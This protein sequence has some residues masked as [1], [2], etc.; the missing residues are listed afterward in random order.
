MA[1][2]GNNSSGMQ[3]E[4]I[5]NTLVN[6]IS[7]FTE[8]SVEHLGYDKTVLAS[9]QYC[10]DATLG[11]YKIKYQNGYYTAY[12]QDKSTIYANGAAVYVLVPGNDM[13]NK[14]FITGLV[15]NDN[16]LRTYI[17]NLD[18]DQLYGLTSVNLFSTIDEIGLSSYETEAMSTNPETEYSLTLYDY[19]KDNNIIALDQAKIRTEIMKSNTDA[20]NDDKHKYLRFGGTF[21]T[22]FESYRKL[23]PGA[24]YGIRL[25]I[26]FQDSNTKEWTDKCYALNTFNME[27]NP[28]EFTSGSPRYAY[29]EIDPN[30]YQYVR[31]IVAYIKGFP[32]VDPNDRHYPLQPDNLFKDLKI[33]DISLYTAKKLYSYDN[34]KYRI[35]LDYSKTDKY[36][37]STVSQIE[38]LAHFTIDGN[39]VIDESQNVK[40]Y[41]GKEDV[42]VD[43]IGHAK[44]NKFL[45]KGWRCI[46]TWYAKKTDSSNPDDLKNCA[47]TAVQMP[48]GSVK[49]IGWNSVNPILLTSA[50][51]KAKQTLIKCVA[52]YEN[53]PYQTTE[54]F[55][56]NNGKYLLVKSSNPT[57]STTT[58][59]SAGVFADNPVEGEPPLNWT[60]RNPN[61]DT[62]SN[63]T[64]IW[65][66]T[67]YAGITRKLPP[68]DPIFFYPSVNQWDYRQDNVNIEDPSAYLNSHPGYST[69]YQR[70]LYYHD[71]LS[72]QTATT[73]G[74]EVATTRLQIM[75]TDRKAE[76]AAMYADN[77]KNET[78]EYLIGPGAV[79]VKK[80]DNS[81]TYDYENMMIDT[82]IP[83]YYGSTEY[84]TYHGDNVTYPKD[85]ILYQLRLSSLVGTVTYKVTAL[86]HD[87]STGEIDAIGTSTIMVQKTASV[88]DYNLEITN[89]TQTFLYSVGG[90]SPSSD[91]ENLNPILIKPLFFKL[92]DKEGAIIYDSESPDIDGDN[93]NTAVDEF[94]PMWK[95]NISKTLLTT[96]YIG[97]NNYSVDANGYGVLANSKNFV[98][99]LAEDY[100]IAYKERSN[101]TLQI[102]YNG[103]MITAATNFTFIKQGEL[104]TNGTNMTLDI[105]DLIYENYR[106]DILEDPRLCTFLNAEDRGSGDEYEKY[107]TSERHLKNGYLYATKVYNPD[108][109]WLNTGDIDQATFTNLLFAQNPLVDD[110]ESLVYTEVISGQE[111]KYHAVEGSLT[112]TLGGYWTENGERSMI[113]PD[114]IWYIDT[115]TVS[116]ASSKYYSESPFSFN[117]ST[118]G[119]KKGAS[120]TLAVKNFKQG[121]NPPIYYKPLPLPDYVLPSGE[122]VTRVSNNLVICKAEKEVVS[123]DNIKRQNFGYY[124]IPF[125]YYNVTRHDEN[126]YHQESPDNIDPARYFVITGGYD[127]VL[128]DN[129]GYNPEYNKQSPFKFHLFNLDHEDITEKVL[130]DSNASINWGCSQGFTQSIPFMLTGN[131]RVKT[132]AE[133]S[134]N[135]SLLHQYCNKDGVIYYCVKRHRKNGEKLIK[136]A[137]GNVIKVYQ[138]GEFIPSFWEKIMTIN[139]YPASPSTQF[140]NTSMMNFTPNPSYQSTTAQDLFNSWVSVTV[141]YTEGPLRY[142]AT[143][144][145]PIN[146]LCNRYGSEEL[147]NWDGKKTVVDDAYIV[148]SKIAA[149]R[150]NNDN[151]FTGITIGETMYTEGKRNGKQGEVGLFGYGKFKRGSE[152]N[153]VWGRTL[154]LDAETGLAMFGPTGST[155]IIL[156]PQQKHLFSSSE[157][158]WSRLAGWYFSKDFLYKPLGESNMTNETYSSIISGEYEIKPPSTPYGSV[159]M[160]VPW[161]VGPEDEYGPQQELSDDTVFIWASAAV[162]PANSSAAKE[163]YN[164]LMDCQRTLQRDYPSLRFMQDYSIKPSSYEK[165]KRTL[166]LAKDHWADLV[167]ALREKK[168]GELIGVIV[169][170]DGRVF[171]VVNATGHKIPEADYE[172]EV[173]PYNTDEEIDAQI[174]VELEREAEAQQDKEDFEDAVS[175]YNTFL[176]TYNGIITSK[177]TKHVATYK[178]FNQKKAS[179]YVTYGGK[180]HCEEAEITGDISA[181][182]GHIGNGNNKIDIA[183]TRSDGY[184]YIL[185]N[186]NFYVRESGQNP[187]VEPTVYMKGRIMANSGAFGRIKDDIDGNSTKTVFIQYSWYPWALPNEDTEWGG[188][189][190]N[191][192][193]PGAKRPYLDVNAGKTTKYIMYHPNFYIKEDGDVMLRGEIY[194][195]KGHLGNWVIN[196]EIIRDVADTIFLKP[197]KP[198][199]SGFIRAGSV[200][201]KDGGGVSGGEI[202]IYQN[203]DLDPQ[204]RDSEPRGVTP[205]VS[206]SGRGLF[207]NGSAIDSYVNT[208]THGTYLTGVTARTNTV[209]IGGTTITYVTEVLPDFS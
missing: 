74:K 204:N 181:R 185:Y 80:I 20:V 37:T 73:E 87:L 153:V 115:G 12:A 92:Y 192:D 197:G 177:Q 133:F 99:N 116:Q 198:G 201:I 93:N 24:D 26:S 188:N 145:I 81:L 22:A 49:E 172:T 100:N 41:W 105:E 184:N 149:G 205:Q 1:T 91:S 66:E 63:I 171:Y 52:V 13:S 203:S 208:M 38:C 104:G 195:K 111:K 62:I 206:L 86:E 118:G 137:E 89:G 101:V 194:C 132:W 178:N 44:Y 21:T 146:I 202:N 123:Q 51:L 179:F 46:N 6:A 196:E 54:Y 190:P 124:P 56:N 36:I 161:H 182:A 135:E 167:Q 176:T 131:K 45:G 114:S 82:V 199:D 191:V 173:A 169:E 57:G 30:G 180:L 67:D 129:T 14:K 207:I 155:Q 5:L 151:T 53:V 166:Q 136:D 39:P 48:D 17:S 68:T 42:S 96:G 16:S 69:C 140:Y 183:V 32:P 193:P 76:L 112:A 103:I 27:G 209:T 170:D 23:Y 28:F 7:G 187:D 106:S 158:D 168:A 58:T 164:N 113:D 150:K 35:W 144:F 83:Y 102:E 8:K 98:Y 125:F 77:Q 18:G 34:D 107:S 117:G 9:I 174:V 119:E 71:Y 84:N 78:G 94:H 70:Y 97:T 121:I 75:E 175:L 40:F 33:K 90:K 163:A 95:F 10:S 200:F 110:N 4:E 65:E 130:E 50:Q 148:S 108:R 29:F 138:S 122:V 85:N 134:G 162:D 154:F 156:N 189:V 143:A 43:S 142:C 59:L 11:Q 47:Y 186:K 19:N 159:G 60:L 152:D 15:D 139:P 109:T 128:Y 61:N 160:Y 3:K 79:T 55:I 165:V 2:N 25:Y 88:L 147:N 31:S 126:G 72:T 64:F 157:Y 127:E 141:K 120:I